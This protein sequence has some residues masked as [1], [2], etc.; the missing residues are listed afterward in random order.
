MAKMKDFTMFGKFFKE[1]RKRRGLTLRQFCLEN[2]LDP[3]NISKLERGKTHPPSS[4]E[5]LEKYASYL[6]IEVGS[7]DWYNFFDYA[8]ACSG[9]I[10]MDVMKDEDLVEKLPFIFR[11][12]RGQKVPKEKLEELVELIRRV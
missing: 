8:A 9:K 7:D 2:N 12:L 1:L 10:P 5:L 3:G 4:R 6:Q 11:T